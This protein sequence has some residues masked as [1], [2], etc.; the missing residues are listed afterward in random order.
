MPQMSE[1]ARVQAQRAR[2]QEKGRALLLRQWRTGSLGPHE[3]I[4]AAKLRGVATSEIDR[5]LAIRAT[6]RPADR[7][8]S[9]SP[10]VPIQDDSRTSKSVRPHSEHGIN[11]TP[12]RSFSDSPPSIGR[13]QSFCNCITLCRSR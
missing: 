8:L 3:F 2:V 11:Y 12:R 13:I 5:R 4:E 10:E 7:P 1:P 6:L 9:P